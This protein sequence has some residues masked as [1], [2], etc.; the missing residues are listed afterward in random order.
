M[1]S[2]EDIV[3]SQVTV[4]DKAPSRPN[5]GMPMLVGYHTAWI[6]RVHEYTD[7]DEM[8]TDGFLATSPLYL[9]AVALK[10]QSPSPA[11]FKVGRLANA[12]TQTV[13]LTIEGAA[14]GTKI[15]GTIN[16]EA[17]S[18]TVP[19]AQT[20][21]QVATA[22]E[23]LVEA[24]AGISST[25][26]VA[27]ITAVSAAGALSS[28]Y[29]DRGVKMQDVTTDP[30][31]TADLAAIQDEDPSWYGL[32]IDCNAEAII[33]AAAI[34]AEAN[35]KLFVTQSSDAGVVDGTVTT[36][37]ASDLKALS[38][39]RTVGA[40]HRG[41]GRSQDWLAAGWMGQC[42][43]ADPGSITW[44][45]KT[46]AGV[47]VD[48]LKPGERSALAAKN[49]TQYES[50]N[51]LAITFEGKTPSGRFIDVTHGVDWLESEIELDQF[52]LLYNSNQGTKLPFEQIG[53]D[54]CSGK[55]EQS[56]QK[57]IKRTVL[58]NEPAPTVTAPKLAETDVADRAVRRLRTMTW[59]GRLSGALH[60]VKIRGRV[61]V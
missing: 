8:L 44:A 7:A 10:S 57:G 51:D 1:P 9:A 27:V 6:E 26:S 43:A 18:Y 11:K 15:T 45:F 49:W 29:F 2:L 42:L 58:A 35:K 36:D 47:S 12:Y 33:T 24:V 60:G 39:A 46:L 52:L 54:A 4:S 59:E 56:L 25:S 38:L 50:V 13:T 48:K 30:G 53:I 21:T 17:I 5:F 41:I 16:G 28:F 19:A 31:I 34:W 32:L 3:D 14:Q 37:I 23:L 20:T 40:Y 55:L 22:V 61:S